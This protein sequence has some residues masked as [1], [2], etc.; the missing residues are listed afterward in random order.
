[1][2]VLQ[3]LNN[4]LKNNIFISVA[5]NYGA[6]FGHWTPVQNELI[7][8]AQRLN[9]CGY[10]V[11]NHGLYKCENFFISQIDCCDSWKEGLELLILN[12]IS[13]DEEVYVFYYEA[14]LLSVNYF[15]GLA[16]N[17][18]NIKFCINIFDMQYPYTTL[19]KN[20]ISLFAPWKIE[21]KLINFFKKYFVI[22]NT[23][24][25][26]NY[27]EDL[28][29]SK[30]DIKYLSLRKSYE[31]LR[32]LA[33]TLERAVLLRKINFFTD[34]VWNNFSCCPRVYF[35]HKF[36]SER[37][38]KILIPLSYKQIFDWGFVDW[39]VILCLMP[40]ALFRLFDIVI[41]FSG[42]DE[43]IT[44]KFAIFVLQI[45]RIKIMPSPS[46]YDEYGK[47]Y[48][49]TDAVLF[50]YNKFYVWHSSGKVLDALVN[51]KPV[52][53]SKRGYAEFHLRKWISY[54]PTYTNPFN[55]ITTLIFF[56][57]NIKKMNQDLF[58]QRIKISYQYSADCAIDNIV[59]MSSSLR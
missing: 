17:Y 1:M 20:K 35:F 49:D 21:A 57:K 15:D 13:A 59:S 48:A 16:E 22:R 40:L 2:S 30:S 46:S 54:A 47:M 55:L 14:G 43:R 38:F 27:C 7:F 39:W 19:Y 51:L 58:N 4:I 50:P 28:L 26:N 44:V 53:C 31:N 32:I 33:E 8:S 52:I 45:F 5:P 56:K 29:L 9:F 37:K 23:Q 3:K 6:N 25:K 41:A 34:N 42:Q 10:I 36:A 12:K 24:S 18:P 11:S